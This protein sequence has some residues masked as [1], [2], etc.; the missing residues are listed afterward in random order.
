MK[1]EQ[2]LGDGLFVG[3]EETSEMVTLYTTDGVRILQQVYL[4]G[5]VLQAF[6]AWYHRALT[7]AA[8]ERAKA[9][10]VDVQ[11]AT[12]QASAGDGQPKC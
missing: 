5:P 11:Q 3:Y 10:S 7:E 2:Y 8:D 12:A 6:I 4:D 1:W 9:G